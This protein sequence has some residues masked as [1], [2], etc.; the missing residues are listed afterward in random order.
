MNIVVVGRGF[1]GLTAAIALREAGHDVELVGPRNDPYSASFA[2][3]GAST[4]KGLHEA[5]QTLFALKIF[6]HK[7]FASWLQKIETLSG[8]QIAKVRG[9]YERFENKEEYFVEQE[10]IY[11]SRFTGLF[12]VDQTITKRTGYDTVDINQWSRNF[13]PQDFWVDTDEYLKALEAAS[14]A[15]GVK[16]ISEEMISNISETQ[17]DAVVELANGEVIRK[18]LIVLAIGSGIQKVLPKELEILGKILFGA[19]GYTAK[20]SSP[21]SERTGADLCAVKELKAVTLHGGYSYMGSTTEKN[22]IPLNI[23]F[24]GSEDWATKK[25]DEELKQVFLGI[26]ARVL[27]D[28][29]SD[30]NDFEWR[31]GMRVRTKDRI[32]L[33]GPVSKHRRILINAGYYKSGLMLTPLGARL[34]VDLVAGQK[35][36]ELVAA[37]QTTRFVTGL[38]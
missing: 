10:R 1:A 19:S 34:L 11:K 3:H 23:P 20:A 2:A 17:A 5:S 15:L 12:C 30:F 37:M 13:Y 8:R 29:P 36:D 9:V 38:T 14:Q 28:R 6:G 7:N 31:W 32:P 21:F 33:V 22:A 24:T 4:I 27:G 25:S 18:D 35:I 26:Y 16:I